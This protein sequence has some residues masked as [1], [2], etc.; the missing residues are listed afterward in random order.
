MLDFKYYF[1][2]IMSK[3]LSQH[4]VGLQGKLKQPKKEKNYTLI[5]FLMFFNI[6]V[7]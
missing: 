5:G 7:C 3:S 2:K 1:V 6:P 4:T